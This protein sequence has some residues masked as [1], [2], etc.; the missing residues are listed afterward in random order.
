MIGKIRSASVIGLDAYPVEVEV[1]IA[2]GLPMFTIVGLPD[3]AVKESRDR[4]RAAVKNTGF[5]FP[6]K[7]I[8]INMAPAD[9]KK[10]GSA[11]DLPMALGILLAD[12]VL[13]EAQVKDFII[14]GE[15]SLNGEVRSIKGALS[16]SVAAGRLKGKR[17]ILP[18]ENADEAAVVKGVEVYGVKTLP[19]VVEFLSHRQEVLPTRVNLHDL[20][21]QSQV[22]DEDYADVKGQ[23][24][25]KR[26]IEVAVAGGHNIIL[27]GP[28]GSGK[29]MLAKRL[30]SIMP[31]MSFEEAIETTRIHSVSGMLPEGCPL[32]SIRPF[33]SPHHTISDVGL[34]GGGQF[35]RPGEVSLA[36]NGVLFLDEV[37]EFH[38]NVLEVLRQ[39]IEEGVVMIVRASAS[40]PTLF[41]WARQAPERRCWPRGCRRSCL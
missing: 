12:G 38:R 20:F 15:L 17:L 3:A 37:P 30:P 8:T 7:K 34:I 4:V 21:S 9:I 2:N 36:H 11:F 14:V 40:R 5:Q 27:V 23:P 29:T 26:A 13:T 16:L 31:L 22:Y 28:P 19:Q 25:A 1:D 41:W 6:V 10:E 33:R 32:I 24:Y 39:P 35:P 18:E